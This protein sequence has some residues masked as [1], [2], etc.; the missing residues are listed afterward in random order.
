MR[1][2]IFWLVGYFFSLLCWG[3][4]HFLTVH[5]LVCGWGT[6]SG[7]RSTLLAGL[8]GA[9]LVCWVWV[10]GE[11]YSGCLHLYFCVILFCLS[12]F[13][14]SDA[15]SFV[16]WCVWGWFICVF[17]FVVFVGVRWMPWYQELMKDVAVCDMPRGVDERVLIRGFLN[18]GTQ[19]L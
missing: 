7:L 1:A 8:F 6:L 5:C 2:N 11:L 18:G 15:F 17:V 16:G 13:L 3:G 9:G 10:V 19:H 4:K 12:D 14:T